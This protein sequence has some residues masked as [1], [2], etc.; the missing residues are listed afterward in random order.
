MDYNQFDIIFWMGD[1]NY[2][3]DLQYNEVI[4]L[5]KENKITTLLENDQLKKFQKIGLIFED[6]QEGEIKFNPTFKLNQE[7]RDYET[8]KMRV[9]SY[10]DRILFKNNNE[11][12]QLIQVDYKSLPLVQSSDHVPVCSTFKIHTQLPF[13]SLFNSNNFE[14]II[15]LYKIVISNRFID[16]LFYFLIKKKK[17]VFIKLIKK[18]KKGNKKTT[19]NNIF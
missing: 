16:V 3:I 13:I 15:F 1:L 12:N 8:K 17:K 10:C 14:K 9:P 19:N 5:I 6:F 11:S 4:E 2:R 7:T 18:K